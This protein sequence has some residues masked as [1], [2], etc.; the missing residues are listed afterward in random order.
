MLPAT[1][2][3]SW[4]S[5]QQVTTRTLPHHIYTR[6]QIVTFFGA[7]FLG[8]FFVS[9]G[10]CFQKDI[11]NLVSTRE[12]IVALI[13]AQVLFLGAFLGFGGHCFQR[14]ILNLVY[15]REHMVAFI[16]EKSLG[17]LLGFGG[18]CSLKDIL[19]WVYIQKDILNLV[20]IREQIAKVAVAF[21]GFQRGIL[22]QREPCTYQLHWSFGPRRWIGAVFL[23]ASV[24]FGDP[25]FLMDILNLVH[26]CECDVPWGSLRPRTWRIR[27]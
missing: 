18:S 5:Q 16:S 13:G 19:Y 6:E 4:D 15:I 3:R 17:A 7:K 2:C 24:D 20:Y 23:W 22:A 8:A 11:L 1:Q 27:K 10:S 12:Q 26:I 25:G 21:L 9:G 14:D